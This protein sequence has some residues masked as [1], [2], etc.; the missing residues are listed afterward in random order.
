[1]GFAALESTGY[2]FTA[3]LLSQ[4]H[5]EASLIET[6]IRG[7]IAPFGHGVWT[8]VLGAVLFRQSTPRHFRING[9]VIVAFLFVSVLHALWDGLPFSIYVII[10]PGIPLSITTLILGVIGI[11][12]LSV[13]YRQ[14]MIQHL[15]Q[16]ALPLPE[17]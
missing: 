10:P 9:P 13:L 17:A 16:S 8:G 7:L 6:V 11:I 3:L 5:I 14:A 2:A 4:G 15:K 1:M 12:T